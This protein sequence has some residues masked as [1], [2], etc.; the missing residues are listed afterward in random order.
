MRISTASFYDAGISSMQRQTE[1]LL[2]VQ[3][4]VSSGRRILTPSDDPVAAA[5]VLDVSQSQSMNQQFGVNAGAAGDILALQE[6]VLGSITDVLQ[7]VRDTVITAGGGVLNQSDRASLAADLRGKYQSL[8]GLANSTDGN[9]Q[10]L[11]SGYQGGT[12][13][14]TESTAGVVDYNGDQGQRLMQISPTRQIAVN[15]A[16]F[17]VFQRIK[18]GNGNFVTQAAATNGGSAVIDAGV[19]IEPGKWNSAGNN[20]DFTIKFAGSGALTSYDIIDNVSGKSLL[21]GLAPGVAP[22]PRTYTAGSSIDLSQSGPPAFDYGAKVGIA[23]IPANGD[24]FSIKASASQSVFKTIDDLANLLEIPT[25]RATLSNGLARQLVNLDNAL[26][27]VSVA[28]VSTGVR[29]T[30][31]ETVKSVGDNRDLQYAQTLS[32]LQDLDYAKATSD[33]MQQQVN[34][35]AAQKSFAK[36]AG[37]SLFDYL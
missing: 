9:G 27:S 37:L 32:R 1:R 29:L 2:Q 19:M 7:S 10:Y 4:Q 33:L 11:F 26:D 13:P 31:L 21:T 23:G 18:T 6:S 34:L 20:R 35:Q 12:R 5:R 14:F 25:S 17:D 28:R 24:S 15:D 36:V 22:Y 8:L 30:E 3:Q 16:G